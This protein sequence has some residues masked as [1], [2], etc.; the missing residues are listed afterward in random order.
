MRLGLAGCAAVLAGCAFDHSGVEGGGGS[1]D[2]DLTAPDANPIDAGC[3]GSQ[4]PFAPVNVDACDLPIS[5]GD[6]RFSDGIAHEIDTST[7]TIR[8]DGQVVTDL[9]HALVVQDGSTVEAMVILAQDLEIAN[10]AEVRVTGTRPLILVAIGELRIDGLLDGSGSLA[11]PGPG[12]DLA[13]ACATGT[14]ANGETQAGNQTIVV[15]GGSGAGGGAYGNA[16]GTGAHVSPQTTID[17]DTVGGTAWGINTLSPL[18]GGCRGGNGGVAED[19]HAAAPGGGGGGAIELVAGEQ[20]RIGGVVT[21]SGGGGGGAGTG[22]P[23][24]LGGGGGGGGS[25]GALLLQS[26]SVLVASGKLTANG[27]GGG[28]GR[29]DTAAG[30]PGAAG[31]A[32]GDNPAQGGSGVAGGNGGDG[33]ALLLL[34]ED[35][36]VGTGSVTATAGGGGGGGGVGRIHIRVSLLDLMGSDVVSPPFTQGGL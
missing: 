4:L 21:V 16:G 11:G 28:E 9:A 35:G 23:T 14:G 22:Q 29:R 19:A 15:Q 6:F 32:T 3:S 13:A 18:T 26:P 17:D 10:G 34:G 2:A 7:N 33:G 24:E 36:E 8:S 30:M 12:G 25:G 5:M 1:P 27:G 31:S 20:V